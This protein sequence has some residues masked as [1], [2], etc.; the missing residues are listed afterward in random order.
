MKYHESTVTLVTILLFCALNLGAQ[1][2][3]RALFVGVGSYPEQSGWNVLNSANDL[4]LLS[5]VLL[6]R[7]VPQDN[8]HLLSDEAATMA[9]IE[10]ALDQL[11]AEAKEGE[12]VWFHFSGHGQQVQDDNAD[13]LDG[14][15]EAL[16]PYDA[17]KNWETGEYEGEKHLRDDKLGKR[18]VDLRL[19]LGKKGSLVITIDACHSGTGTRGYANARGTDVIMA[20]SAWL[21]SL[22][23]RIR[24]DAGDALENQPPGADAA[25]WVL[26]FSSAPHELSFETNKP[27]G[28]NTGLFTAT[29]ARAFAQAN[30]QTTYEALFASVRQHMLG[31]T[32]QQTPQIEGDVQL[33]LGGGTWM[34]SP[35]YFA[36]K[37]VQDAQYVT[38]DAGQLQG[39]YPGAQLAFYA[40]EVSDT[41]GVEPFARG[42]AEAGDLFSF[43]VAL[44]AP[45]ERDLLSTA[46]V[47]Q[48]RAG[49][50][51]QAAAIRVDLPEGPLRTAVANQIKQNPFLTWHGDQAGDFIVDGM[52]TQVRLLRADGHELTR[53]PADALP[54]EAA[55]LLLSKARE[56]LLASHLRQLECA[57]PL[58][59]A[60]FELVELD[61]FTPIAER[62][63]QAGRQFRLLV[64]NTGT[65]PF[66][67]SMLEIMANDALELLSPYERPASEYFLAPGKQYASEFYIETTDARGTDVLKLLLSPAPLSWSW[68]QASRGEAPD[69]A[70]ANLL[71][72]DALRDH[73]AVPDA[74]GDS[75]LPGSGGV[76]S[77][78]IE[79]TK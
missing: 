18:L 7:G 31:V 11:T 49:S 46:K 44:N 79:T 15:D 35:G 53:V 69:A 68:L 71:N 26:L 50:A 51:F 25:P 42:V 48:T 23:A 5:E 4:A 47:W 38:I 40:P 63:F 78:L 72:P 77:L 34:A 57:D 67:F 12:T 54:D 28:H 21:K 19:R 6:A 37:S 39:I 14:L 70:F 45:A 2:N 24:I 75:R 73:V 9:G 62:R 20:D 66:Y 76:I 22:S 59:K 55:R 29:V 30:P 36:V 33:H 1:T 27:D 56:N 10:Q 43:D 41:A 64:E 60:R 61:G 13:E 8:I 65:E 3:V 52:A 16:V 58:F 74:R 32:T 17:Q